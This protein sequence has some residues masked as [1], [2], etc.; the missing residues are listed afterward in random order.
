MCGY[1]GRLGATTVAL[2][3]AHVRWHAFDG[4]DELKNAVCLCTLHHKLF[5]LGAVGISDDRG[6]VVSAQFVGRGEVAERLVTGLVGQALHE[7]QRGIPPPI[8]EH[9]GWHQRQVFRPPARQPA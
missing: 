6:M 5:D 9:V 1:D 4:P 8:D 7:P 2:D 3:A